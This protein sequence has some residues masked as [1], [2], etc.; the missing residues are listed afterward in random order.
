MI[1]FSIKDLTATG[2]AIILDNGDVL[3]RC[4]IT[5][6]INGIVSNDKTL[7]DLIEFT[8]PNTVMAGSPTPI[9]TG[10]EYIKNTLAPEW[11]AINYAEI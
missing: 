11:V 4:L 6:K 9:L 8:I 1:T 3:Q 2:N 10:W 5:V 7:N